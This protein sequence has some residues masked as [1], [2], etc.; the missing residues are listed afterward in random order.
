VQEGQAAVVLVKCTTKGE[1]PE[2]TSVV[3]FAL[4]CALDVRVNSVSSPIGIHLDNT[5]KTQRVTKV[6]KGTFIGSEIYEGNI[7]LVIFVK[8]NIIFCFFRGYGAA[9]GTLY[10][11][12]CPPLWDVALAGRLV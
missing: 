10:D 8:K 1:H 5:G 2:V 7:K 6:I 3:K 12:R 9:R 4:T 11:G